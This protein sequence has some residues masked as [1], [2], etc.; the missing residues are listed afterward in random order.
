[1]RFFLALLLLSCGGSSDGYPRTVEGITLSHEGALFRASD[2]KF[3]MQF[4]AAPDVESETISP[5]AKMTILGVLDPAN[6][7]SLHV[8]IVAIKL[9]TPMEVAALQSGTIL[10]A[11]ITDPTW[12]DTS[13]A[14][15]PARF[16][17][18]TWHSEKGELFPS[19]TWFVEA[20][21]QGRVYVVS[22]IEYPEGILDAQATALAEHLKLIDP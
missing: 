15:R 14:G 20:P 12:T 9:K 5:T 17:R 1:M 4:P 18:G 7:Y 8:E 11:H 22:L 21:K 2:D 16:A 13:L 3:E 19:R 10:G 6:H